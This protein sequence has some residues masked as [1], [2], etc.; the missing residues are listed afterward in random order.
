M[1]FLFYEKQF[2]CGEFT[3]VMNDDE[4]MYLEEQWRHV[5]GMESETWMS[6]HGSEPEFMRH[7]G[8]DVMSEMNDSDIMYMKVSMEHTAASIA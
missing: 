7:L 2:M 8:S 1:V 4:W 3:L 6:M 5:C